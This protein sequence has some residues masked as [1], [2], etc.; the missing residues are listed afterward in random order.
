[1]VSKGG[2]EQAWGEQNGIIGNEEGRLTSEATM[3]LDNSII[4]TNPQ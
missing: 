4:V 3:N 1:V 2:E